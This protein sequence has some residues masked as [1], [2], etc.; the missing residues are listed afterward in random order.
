MCGCETA[1]F[2]RCLCYG[3]M[4]N[5]TPALSSCLET[6]FV[7][8]YGPPSPFYFLDYL[9]KIYEGETHLKKNV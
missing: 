7:F 9:D 5:H 3:E 2:Q 8:F 6:G 1:P 4:L